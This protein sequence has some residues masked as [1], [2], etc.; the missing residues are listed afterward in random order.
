MTKNPRLFGLMILISMALFVG[1]YNETA[2]L[3]DNK[4]VNR[5]QEHYQKAQPVH[6]YDFSI[7]RD[8][9]QQI[10][11]ITTQ[12]AV[13]TYTVIESVTG[14]PRFEC[15]SISYP[16]TFDVSL[17]NPLKG[18]NAVD[19]WGADSYEAVTEQAE[20]NGLYPSK[21]TDATWVLCVDTD[22]GLAY[23]FFSEHKANTWPF[24]VE[25]NDK[26]MWQRAKGA[27]IAFK[28]EIRET[29]P[30]KS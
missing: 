3:T 16:I 7:P 29:K 1:C 9:Y 19:H 24:I 23:A 2:D 20:P 17:T 6:F 26:N 8:I 25:L 12:Q 14:V 4:T 30:E 28:V 13:A 27:P 21:N 22:S 11:D 10:Y 5:Q 15:P 18:V